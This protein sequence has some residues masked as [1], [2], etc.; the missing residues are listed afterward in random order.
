MF[1]TTLRCKYTQPLVVCQE[2]KYNYFSFVN[3]Y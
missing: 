3:Y 2:G 1:L